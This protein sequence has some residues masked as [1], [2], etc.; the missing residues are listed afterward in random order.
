[1]S[2]FP[3]YLGL[4]GATS[5][6]LVLYFLP[7]SKDF[8]IHTEY[9]FS[10]HSE[11]SLPVVFEDASL[12]WK[13]LA[14]HAQSSKHLTALTETLGGGVCAFDFNRD[15]WMDVFFVG[16]SGHSRHYGRKVWWNNA[17][18]NRLLLNKHGRYF[19]DVTETAGLSKRIWGMSCAVADF[20]N[21]GFGDLLVTGVNSN[22]LYK[23]NGDGKF[24]DITAQS[25]ID[26][27]HWST[28]S[29]LGDFNGDGLLDIYVTNYIRYQKGARTFERTSGFKTTGH[30]DFDPTL[31]DP[32]PNQLYLNH[33][34][35]KFV[36][37]AEEAG[38]LNALGRS[39]GA[40]WVD[41]NGDRW[42]DLIVINDHN[43]PNQ[44]FI[45]NQGRT[46]ER[47]QE[48]YAA[49]EVAGAHDL[50]VGDFSRNGQFDFF[51]SRGMSHAPVL[52]SRVDENSP[53]VD[54]AWNSG[55][56]QA[57]RLPYTGWGNVA[58]D[59]NNDG[60]LDLYVANGMMM[61]DID[62]HFV[63]QAQQNSLYLNQ[64]DQRFSLA[65][66]AVVASANLQQRPFS[67]RSVITVDLDNDGRLELIVGNNNDPLQV[68]TN[69]VDNRQSWIGLDLLT[70]NIAAEVYGAVLEISTESYTYRQIVH[71]KQSFLAQGDPR[72]HFGLGNSTGVK[73]LVLNWPDGKVSRFENLVPNQYFSIDKSN[74]TITP[75]ETAGADR[76]DL[77]FVSRLSESELAAYARL[78]LRASPAKAQDELNRVWQTGGQSIKEMLLS[79]IEKQ[80]DFR[81][82]FMLRQALQSDVVSLRVQAIEIL[83]QAELEPGVAWLLPLLEDSSLEVRCAAAHTFAV[84][85]DEEEAVTHRK[86]L[87]I[88]SLIKLL[89]NDTGEARVCAANALAR[90][91]SKRAILPLLKLLDDEKS[92]T[93]RAAAARALGLIRD[94]RSRAGLISTV[95]DHETPAQV[96]AS[97]LIALR[98]LNEADL[99]MLLEFVLSPGQ[100]VREIGYA[101]RSYQILTYL[102]SHP[103]GIVLPRKLLQGKLKSLLDLD[104][105]LP[106]LAGSRGKT[107]TIAILQAI[108]A[109]R[110]AARLG[111]V[112][113]MLDHPDVEVQLS[114]LQTLAALNTAQSKRLLEKFLEGSSVVMLSRFLVENDYN[115]LSFSTGFIELWVDRI[116]AET[117]TS[118]ELQTLL[119]ELPKAAA[120]EVFNRLLERHLS[121]SE[122]LQLFRYCESQ[123]NKFFVSAFYSVEDIRAKFADNEVLYAFGKC[124]F[125]RD[126]AVAD[127]AFQLRKLLVLKTLLSDHSHD[128]PADANTTLLLQAAG[129]D[130]RVARV[131]LAQKFVSNFGQF[132]VMQKVGAIRILARH[133]LGSSVESDLWALLRDKAETGVVRLSAAEAL[134][135]GDEEAVLGYIENQFRPAADP[136]HG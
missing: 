128:L 7:A 93:A 81:Y 49:F 84:F 103:D 47:G 12:E 27:S 120:N 3:L 2:R 61:P 59:F 132:S 25:G 23:N 52:L 17:S 78:L 76:L 133:G 54:L 92:V 30:V 10:S 116:T 5:L 57:S 62:S 79:G 85:F 83:R 95:R 77:H 73:E 67:S 41:L 131:M 21:D 58:A 89:E 90:A 127:Q 4:C 44:V 87:A 107:H 124:Y 34:D 65:R 60:W 42:L 136:G 35:F 26:S 11:N 101:T 113:D 111:N 53:Y 96:V 97:A 104:R 14:A 38:V 45:S 40:R 16:G 39:L 56:A 37:V 82:A 63:P 106:G 121:S 31:Y 51:M 98:R 105:S 55:L 69:R 24:V 134:M 15:G 94:T 118:N 22:T 1:M 9:G 33:G 110:L 126:P 71:A 99:P 6:L 18:G 115:S 117:L 129:A 88:S 72:V 108:A 135:Q 64:G 100:A 48:G 66:P 68:L 36:D 70:H 29:S 75:L 19:E 28:S 125:G 102:L 20:D 13:L 8:A 46:F 32:E 43:S 119:V 123:Q 130:K 112:T 86:H 109:A 50:A 122:Y 114:A 80:W 91:E 74:D